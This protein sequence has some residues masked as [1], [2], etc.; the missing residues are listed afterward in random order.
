MDWSL[1]HMNTI[2]L[3]D[4]EMLMF[5]IQNIILK[6]K[7]FESGFGLWCGENATRFLSAVVMLAVSSSGW[8]QNLELSSVFKAYLNVAM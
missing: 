5:L 1:Q 4:S 3:S 8:V 6:I 2:T 7:A